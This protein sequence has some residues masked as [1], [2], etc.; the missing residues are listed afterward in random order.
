MNEQ[1]FTRLAK[2]IVL[3]YAQAHQDPEDV[4]EL[5]LEDIYVVWLC[6]TLQNNKALLSTTV[7]DTRYYELTYDGDKQAIYFDAYVKEENKAILV[8]EVCDAD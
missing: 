8:E 3:D 2:K 1:S 5:A 6:K 4:R 7:P